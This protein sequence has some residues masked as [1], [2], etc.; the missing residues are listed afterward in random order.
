[1]LRWENEEEEPE[2]THQDHQEEEVLLLLVEQQHNQLQQ[3]PMSKLWAKTL[4]SS[5][6]IGKRPIPS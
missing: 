3:R 2:E 1:M 6:E 5:S 4:P